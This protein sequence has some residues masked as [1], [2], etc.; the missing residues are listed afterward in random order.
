VMDMALA[1]ADC[2]DQRFY[3]MSNMIFEDRADYYRV[4]EH[5]QKSGMDVTDWSIWFLGRMDAALASAEGVVTAV[6]AKQKFWDDN[7]GLQ[8]NERQK[9]IVNL[10][11]DGFRGK[12]QASKYAAITKTSHDTA[13]RDLSDLVEQEI[14][15]QLGQGRGTH[16][17]LRRF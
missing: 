11:I 6:K 16:Y 14:L 2:T 7:S 13:L 5:S 10:L 3:S 15:V 9:K 8:M 1:R 17:E 4:L 12:L